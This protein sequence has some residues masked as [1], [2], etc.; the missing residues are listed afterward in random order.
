MVLLPAHPG[1]RVAGTGEVIDAQ[2]TWDSALTNTWSPEL[3]GP[4][5]GTKCMPN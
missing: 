4:E 1:N 2:F 5:K 3:P